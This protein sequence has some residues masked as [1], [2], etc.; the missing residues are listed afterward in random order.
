MRMI[1]KVCEATKTNLQVSTPSL[2]YLFHL[3]NPPVPWLD[4][5]IKVDFNPSSPTI[6]IDI[7]TPGEVRFSKSSTQRLIKEPP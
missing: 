1:F 7:P 5:S 6:T 3:L 2:L 4:F